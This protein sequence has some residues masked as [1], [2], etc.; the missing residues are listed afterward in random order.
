MN[1]FHQISTSHFPKLTYRR[2]GSGPALMLL[3]GFPAS[4][5][6][7]SEV[8]FQLSQNL[9]LLIPDIPGTGESE[10]KN[11]DTSMEELATLV[12]EILDDSGISQ[13]VI[14]GHSMGG[15]I[16]LAAAELFPERIKGLSLVHSTANP[17]DDE[18]KEKRKKAIALI[19][20]GG[21]DA[22]VKGMIPPLFSESFRK[23]HPETIQEQ[24]E[25]GM[26]IPSES[27]IA[28]YNAM[29]ARPSRLEV[30]TGADFPVQWIFGKEDET[31]PWHPVLAQCSLPLR[32][33]VS[34]YDTCAHMSML[35][36]KELLQKDLIKFVL[37][38]QQQ[39]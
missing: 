8:Q 19:R 37:F 21:G 16:A 33:F 5:K 24:I 30:L 15:Y 25:E 26:K 6:L 38:C 18:K 29:I 22:F 2:Y 9:T 3:H 4:G 11:A 13:C 1:P 7:W 12:P 20:K 17:D 34:L 31:I 14:A 10:L 35:E 32:S 27:L 28:F 23:E 36:Q 39:M